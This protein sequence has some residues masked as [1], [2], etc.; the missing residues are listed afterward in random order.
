[1]ATKK[2]DYIKGASASINR[3]INEIEQMLQG[4][5]LPKVG[6]LRK[7]LRDRLEEMLGQVAMEWLKDGFRGG[8]TIAARRF[9]KTGV[10]PQL[11][12]AKVKRP[13]PIQSVSSNVVE[14]AVKSRLPKAVAAI[15]PGDA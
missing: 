13:F 1:M 10:F 3:T 9:A 7:D 5:K 14:L 8:H 15:V 6:G 4:N 11:I 12:D 2:I